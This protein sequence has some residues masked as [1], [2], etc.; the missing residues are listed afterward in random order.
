MRNLL[1]RRIRKR[2]RNENAYVKENLEPTQCDSSIPLGIE[3]AYKVV[4]RGT[5]ELSEESI[6]DYSFFVA[7][8][9]LKRFD[10]SGVCIS[11]HAKM[12]SIGTE[13]SQ[14]P[15][16]MAKPSFPSEANTKEYAQSLDAKDHMRSFREKFIIP[17]KANIKSKKVAKPGQPKSTPHSRDLY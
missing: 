6:I 16:K 8:F 2:K 4:L 17:S 3:R 13:Q 9:Q 14:S 12:G 15:T 10:Y 11:L 7:A 5:F 1:R